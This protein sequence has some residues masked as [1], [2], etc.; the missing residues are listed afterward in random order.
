MDKEPFKAR[1]CLPPTVL[2][3]SLFCISLGCALESTSGV[4]Q[5]NASSVTPTQLQ[6]IRSSLKSDGSHKISVPG[7]MTRKHLY[8]HYELGAPN[9]VAGPHP[10]ANS[11]MVRYFGGN[12]WLAGNPTWE[13]LEGARRYAY[14]REVPVTIQG[15]AGPLTL[16][17]HQFCAAT[18]QRAFSRFQE[19]QNA[20]SA[21]VAGFHPWYPTNVACSNFVPMDRGWDQF[22]RNNP[23]ALS[24]HSV[25]IAC[26]FNYGMGTNVFGANFET[27][28]PQLF[29]NAMLPDPLSIAGLGKR[30][31]EWGGNWASSSVTKGGLPP[32]DKFD[33][34]H[35]E[36][37]FWQ[38]Y[39]DN[40]YQ[41]YTSN[42]NIAPWVACVRKHFDP[43][44][45]VSYQPRGL[46][47]D[48]ASCNDTRFTDTGRAPIL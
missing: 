47:I 30:E 45:G 3:A 19:Y 14:G 48:P 7:I 36:C 18:F 20:A 40:D 26:D 32:V 9:G 34:M 10:T 6:I 22:D 13:Q 37:A 41:D 11:L 1:R 38:D 25:S 16:S 2:S 28:L 39:A 35:F 4:Q 23:T 5:D 46:V 21:Q 43:T 27:D 24:L 44:Y 29:V 17:V 12:P 15:A 42:R 33:P 31:F 8:T